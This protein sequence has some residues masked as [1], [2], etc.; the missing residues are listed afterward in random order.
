MSETSDPGPEAKGGSAQAADGGPTEADFSAGKLRWSD[1]PGEPFRLLFP[2]GL[3]AGVLAVL[4]WPLFFYDLWFQYPGPSH[5]RIMIMGFFGA[6]VIGFLGTAAPRMLEVRPLRWVELGVLLGLF[7]TGTTAYF[8]GSLATGDVAFLLL[9]AGFAGMLALRFPRRSDLPPPSFALVLWGYAHLPA[10]LLFLLAGGTFGTG[11]PWTALGMGFVAEGAFLCMITGVG[12]F[13]F[14]RLLGYPPRQ[15]FAGGATPDSEWFRRAATPFAIGAL[16]FA[17]FWVEHMIHG[18]TGIALRY[19]TVSAYLL[20][21][22][23]LWRKAEHPGFL[24]LSLK[25]GLAAVPAGGFAMAL[26]PDYRMAGIHAVLLTGFGMVTLVVATRVIFGHSGRRNQIEGRVGFFGV[27][28]ALTLAAAALRFLAD[29]YPGSYG[30][31]L[32]KSAF[33]WIAGILVWARYTVPLAS[34]PDP[35]E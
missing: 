23:P 1:I 28:L 4:L 21:M 24:T 26:F 33:F 30:A 13:F 12:A 9:F 11:V 19:A 14:P 29:I 32:G 16:V 20:R 8:A 6:F 5:G 27:I 25:I 3:L 15:R 17:S 2:L 35:E 7:L 34:R 10:G 18:A 31:F 22:V